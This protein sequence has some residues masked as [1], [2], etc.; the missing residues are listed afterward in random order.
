MKKHQIAIAFVVVVTASLSLALGAI[1]TNLGDPGVLIGSK[2]IH[3][4]DGNILLTNSIALPPDVGFFT[5]RDVTVSERTVEWLPPDTT[6]GFRDYSDTDG[7]EARMQVVLMKKDRTSI[8]KPEYCLYGSGM[9][10]TKTETVLIP[11]KDPVPY[12]LPAT[13]ISI[14][15]RIEQP[16]GSVAEWSGFYFYWFVSEDQIVA[17]H[18]SRIL[19]MARDLLQNQVLKRWAYISCLSLSSPGNEAALEERMIRLI[20]QAVPK[21]QLTPPPDDLRIASR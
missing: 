21:F 6:Y 11:M 3:D 13:K 15:R 12:E 20:Q 8:H 7:F 4:N 2:P 19:L 18:K 10:I 9:K 5:G 17:D 14:T 16:D 1:R